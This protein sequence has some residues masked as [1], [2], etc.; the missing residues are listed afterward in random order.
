VKLHQRLAALPVD[1]WQGRRF[2]WIGGLLIAAIAA[3]AAYD[4][5]RGYQATVEETQRELTIQSRVIAEQTARSVQAVDV[6]L[7][8]VAAEYRRGRLTKLG[9]D[10]LHA[11]LRDITVGLKQIDGLGM[12]DAAG[13]QIAVSWPEPRKAVNMAKLPRFAQLRDDPTLDFVIFEAARA[14]GDGVSIVPFGRRLETPGGQFA[15]VVA[16]RGRVDYFEQFY[17][18]AYPEPS[19]RVALLHR[20]AT[21]LARHPPSAAALG[22][23]FPV[24]EGLLPEPGGRPVASRGISP[25]DGVD[26]FA[27]IRLVPDYPLVVV[28]TREASAAL[29]PWRS[30]AIG[31][32][33]RT[34]ALGTLATLLIATVWR[35][36]ARL[37]AARASLAVSEERY[38]LAAAGS[39]TGVWD[40]DLVAGSAYESRRARELQG[41][42]LE[43][44]T[45]PLDTLQG[46]LTYHADDAPLRAAAMQ[47]HLDGQTP[48]Y[49]VEYRVERADGQYRWIHV[50]ALCTRAADGTPLR[51]A[52]SVTDIDD[53]KRGEIALRISEQRFADAVAGADDGIWEWDYTTGMAFGSERGRVMLGLLP[54]GPQ[55]QKME[56]FF[57]EMRERIHPDDAPR[58][59][60]AIEDHLAGR[61]PAYVGDFRMHQADG[62]WRWIHIHG[63]CVRDG[64]GK[65]LR[66]AGSASDIDDRK[67]AEEALRESEERY[68]LAMTGSRGGHWVW[69][70]ASDTLFVSDAVNELFGLPTGTLLHASRRVYRDLVR[71]H[72]D[73]RARNDR[74][75]DDLVAGRVQRAE[76]ES[77][78]LQ[79]DGSARW[80]LTRAQRFD[81]HGHGG[82]R[83]LR[84]AGVSVDISERKR[85][86]AERERLEQQLRQAQKLEAIGT[87]AGGIAHDFN[88]ILSAILGYG[89]LA[90]KS[91]PEGSAQRRHLDASLAAGQRAKSLVERILA[92]SRSGMGERVPVH[93][94]SVAG[95]ALDAVAATLPAGVTLERRLA[96][97]DCGVLG[98]ATQIHQVVMNLCANAVQAMKSEGRLVVTLNTQRLAAP[99]TVTTSTLPTG[100]VLRLA[101]ADSGSGI[102]PRLLERIFDPFFTTKEVGVGT[103]LGLSLV[104]GIVTDLGGGIDVHSRVGEGSTFTIY[105]PAHGVVR[106]PAG[107]ASAADDTPRGDGQTVLLVDDEEPLVRLGEELLAGLGYEPVGFVSS[108]AA[109]DA[110]RA[111]PAR[112]DAVLSD[113]SMPGVTGRELA[114]EAR[115]LRSGLP[116]VLMSGYVSP[117]LLQ[118]A[119][120]IGVAD[121]LAKPLAGREIARALAAALRSSRA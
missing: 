55:V 101:V 120:E 71:W 52:G 30:Q 29:A 3:L 89:E 28:V 73:D 33:W 90:Q 112:F 75:D 83:G 66:M 34:L 65:P 12:F 86:E 39:D 121:V 108:A 25:V 40:W 54:G 68:M 31:T 53:R 6:M 105:L 62:S 60:Q 5:W 106:A 15:G 9:P 109:L 98:D 119:R 56:D 27:A 92:F 8:H 80:V 44:E 77:R 118:Q 107:E 102:E 96:A 1:A 64:D 74:H 59:A 2:A 99:L 20:N 45:Q 24:L 104:H 100:D 19:T 22:Q 18:D 114:I 81:N 82:S 91:A 88:N 38:A 14:A 84:I 116:V 78:V 79:A 110:L 72:P 41:L 97:G 51:I 49:E 37:N 61:T 47:A 42:P 26:R 35:Q 113:E 7:R 117:A 43:P 36:L 4:M 94:Q 21:L 23:R 63:M 76:F 16:A 87:L 67:R 93:V 13:E 50:R 95:E 70:V 57:A 103:G 11:Y 10:E 48:H 17:R 111:A 32:A 58:R 85:A 115:R 69:D 46:L